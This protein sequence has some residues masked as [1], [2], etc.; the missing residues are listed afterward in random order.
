[1]QL[2]GQLDSS[3]QQINIKQFCAVTTMILLILI[4]PSVFW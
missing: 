2:H 1:M 4:I 3:I